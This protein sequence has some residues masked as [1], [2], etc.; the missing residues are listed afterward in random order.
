M[1]TLIILLGICV[2]SLFTPHHDKKYNFSLHFRLLS[3]YTFIYFIYWLT[4][5]L[6]EIKF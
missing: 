2:I 6:L 1:K 3:A 4:T 5:K